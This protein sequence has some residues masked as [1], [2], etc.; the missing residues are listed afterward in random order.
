MGP[1]PVREQGAGP[2]AA[3]FPQPQPSPP[4]P[5]V[6]SQSSAWVGTRYTLRG[7]L[8]EGARVVGGG[9]P[10]CARSDTHASCLHLGSCRRGASPSR[11]V[12]Q[13]STAHRPSQVSG[14]AAKAVQCLAPSSPLC[15][16]QLHFSLCSGKAEGAALPCLKT[17][18]LAATIPHSAAR[19]KIQLYWP[20]MTPLLSM[21]ILERA[22]LSLPFVPYDHITGGG[23]VPASAPH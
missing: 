5:R 15:S 6:C 21:N 18:G 4:T 23:G 2:G 1:A 16:F 7:L 22:S 9:Q 12:Q 19:E 11:A 3:C 20:P 13:C 8:P 17:T 14:G 10:G